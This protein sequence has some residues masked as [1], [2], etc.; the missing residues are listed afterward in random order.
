[1]TADLHI[2]EVIPLMIGCLS[3]LDHSTL[4]RARHFRSRRVSGVWAISSTSAA[5]VVENISVFYMACA[6]QS[7]EALPQTDEVVSF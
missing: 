7:R 1:M 5:P 2:M 6:P 3:F 4:Q